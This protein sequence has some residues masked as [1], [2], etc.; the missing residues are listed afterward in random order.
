MSPSQSEALSRI[1][2]PEKVK[3]GGTRKRHVDERQVLVA[4]QPALPPGMSKE[5]GAEPHERA[6]RVWAF[7]GTTTSMS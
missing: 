1:T 4:N 3:L 5:L 7:L 2:T 6:W